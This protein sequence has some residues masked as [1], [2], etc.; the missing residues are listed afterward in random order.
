M[1]EPGTSPAP[2]PKPQDDILSLRHHLVNWLFTPLY[3]LLLFSTMTGYI[4][5]VNLSNRPYD[6][7]L[8]ERARLLTN[9]FRDHDLSRVESLFPSGGEFL[10][11]LYDRDGKALLG[12]AQLPHPRPGDLNG[13]ELRL[14]DIQIDGRK[15]RLLTLRFQADRQGRPQE[16]VIQAGEATSDRQTLGRSILGNI[17]IP[18]I[19]FIVIAG[20][21]VWIGIK[22]GFQPLERLRREVA[23]RPRNDLRPLEE[24]MAPAEVR[25]FIR[26]INALL[27]RIGA[28]LESQRRFVAD[29]AHQL[30]TPFAGLT[31]QAELARREEDAPPALRE[32]LYR[33]HQGAQRCSRL[34][35]QH[36]ALA[37]NEPEA[38][39]ARLPEPLDL[40]R[41]A[42]SAAMD[43]GPEAVRKKVDL[44][45]EAPEMQLPVRG[46]EG[47]LRDL[48]DN[49]L[50][51]A[52][53]Y[54]PPGGHVTVRLGYD[55]SAW[56]A[57][58]DDGP[59]IPSDLREKVFE[60]F[61]R[62]PGSSQPGT[63]L[64][65][66]IVA[67][68]AARHGAKITLTDGSGGRGACF[69]AR[70]PHHAVMRSEEP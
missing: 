47:P 53:R 27:A 37:R 61:W 32:S 9:H 8:T 28:M 45:L 4:A 5:A 12:N 70:F 39:G 13:P 31:A 36:L 2:A 14:R 3:L 63:G 33:I 43:W 65:L 38:A 58:E 49:L 62:V 48:I 10:Y 40:Y 34:V 68:V 20:L 16:Y 69:T 54:T 19:I 35:S 7:V 23:E 25:P 67:E 24:G 52:I 41:L 60:R 15:F 57:V 42:Q 56:L 59:G 18:Q 66:S 11:T 26:E 1:S 17:V 22:R 51:N 21:A 64:G 30:R 55:D 6:V 44:A 29:A 46:E 50:D